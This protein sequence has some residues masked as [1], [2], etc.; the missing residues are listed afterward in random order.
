MFPH[1]GPS[2]DAPGDAS[3]VYLHVGRLP[4]PTEGQP[5]S[6]TAAWHHVP[7]RRLQVR[8]EILPIRELLQAFPDLRVMSKHTGQVLPQHSKTFSNLYCFFL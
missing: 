4:L 5:Q 7:L 1:T 6:G 2:T 8:G 3:S